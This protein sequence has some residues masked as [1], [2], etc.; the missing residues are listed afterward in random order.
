MNEKKNIDRLFQ[1]KFKDYE[2][3]PPADSWNNIEARLHQKQKKR[4]VPLWFQLSGV[5]A[6][7][8]LGWFFIQN[9]FSRLPANDE[10]QQVVS[11]PDY[12][13]STNSSDDSQSEEILYPNASIIT[14]TSIVD[15]A[16]TGSS[17]STVVE[18]PTNSQ[19]STSSISSYKSTKKIPSSKK[20]LYVN[21]S[22][23][24]A[25]ETRNE[26]SEKI[27]RNSTPQNLI[28]KNTLTT[29]DEMP[30]AVNKSD[31]K[32]DALPQE[33]SINKIDSAAIATAEFNSLEKLLNEKE[34]NVTAEEQKVN[35]WQIS[36]NVA[37]IYFSSASEASPIDPQF[38]NKRKDYKQN[39]SYGLGVRYAISPKLTVRTGVNTIG[40]EYSTSDAVFYQ[41]SNARPLAH[42]DQNLQASVLQIESKPTTTSMEITPNSTLLQKF[43]ATINQRTGYFE[44]P[45]ELSYKLINKK[46]EVDLIGGMST[47]FLNENVIS[48]SSSG[49]TM[50]IGKANN[51]N[52]TH[53]STNV[54][55]GLKYNFLGSFQFNLEPMFKYQINTYTD[56]GNYQPFFFGIYSG[57]NYR[58]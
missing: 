57:V 56:S 38:S 50:E 23:F 46:F 17:S 29:E 8:I 34:N 27:Q 2:V 32:T 24:I 55:V 3:A 39:L 14:E 15:N 20:Q 49:T 5:A 40:M 52:S 26:A 12:T 7:L 37:P 4:I 28:D 33:F 51:L 13:P 47:L 16:S 25:D 44:V 22:Q 19:K 30:I 42:V 18:N 9:N 54:G 35:R 11:M 10:Q 6:A 58:F 45:V 53:F 31:I 43:D 41:S 1:E 36:S 48:M 21:G